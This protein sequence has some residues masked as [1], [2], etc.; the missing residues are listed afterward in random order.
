MTAGAVITVVTA[1]FTTTLG[2]RITRRVPFWFSTACVIHV[3]IYIVHS[4]I[5][6]PVSGQPVH[7]SLV[8]RTGVR[9]RRRDWNTKRT[10]D[11]GSRAPFWRIR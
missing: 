11:S 1:S 10:R 8:V 7:K 2:E 5:G 3:N 4:S 9:G 6:C